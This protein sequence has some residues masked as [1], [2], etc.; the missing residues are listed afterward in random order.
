MRKNWILVVLI[1]FVLVLAVVV[2]GIL[3]ISR[4]IERTADEALGP[5]SSM[6]AGLG[7]QVASVLHP[8]PTILPDPVTI[9][10]EVRSLAR[11]E[12]IQ[13]SMEKVITAEIGQE[14][15]PG[16][17]GDKLLFVAHGEIIAGVDLAKLNPDDIRVEGGVLYVRLPEAEIFVSRLDN[18]KSY[19]YDRETGLLTHGNINLETEARRAAEDEMRK[20]AVDDGILE[21]A[22][23]NA[24]N[25]L[26]RLLRALGYP[27]V[28]FK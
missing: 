18:E 26:S 23:L 17:F 12:T 7:T 5:I 9:V 27:E 4:T 6:Q 1:A 24:E 15:L 3:Q 21:Q 14:M 25:Y 10:H 2:I 16:L 20:S 13:Y 28:V 8:T 22:Q 11:L 19:V